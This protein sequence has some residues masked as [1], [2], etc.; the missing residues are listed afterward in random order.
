MDRK[1]FNLIHRPENHDEISSLVRRLLAKAD[2]FDVLPTPIDRLFEIARV[3]QIADLPEPSSGFLNSMGERAFNAL[4]S[5]RQKIRGMADMR[6]RVVYIPKRDRPPRILFA[7]GHE[8]G[9]QCMPWHNIEPS[10]QD[11]DLTL[12]AKVKLLFEQ[13]ANDFSA[14]AI[15]QGALRFQRRA[16]DYF[17]D[18]DSVFHLADMHGASKQATAWHFVEEQD[19]A[20]AVLYYYP[21][22]WRTDEA[23]NQ[24]LVFWKAAASPKFREQYEDIDIPT[25]LSSSH[26]WVA[27]RS[28]NEIVSGTD[29]FKFWEKGSISFQWQAWWNRYTLVVLLR[30]KPAI[31]AVKNFLWGQS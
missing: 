28:S 13:E 4:V 7:Q 9:H 27:A 12:S 31:T 3:Q 30:R 11:D 26:A 15:F 16:R 17:V 21:S 20:V 6:S 14:E 19:R 2:A 8:L 18:F 23:G 10:Y 5:A 24:S 22:S 1:K 25:I 29:E